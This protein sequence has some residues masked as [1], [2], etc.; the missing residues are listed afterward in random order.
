MGWQDR[1]YNQESNGGIPPVV[2]KFPKLSRLTLTLL[3]LNLALFLLKAVWEHGYLATLHW[4]ALELT[5]GHA[6]TQPWRWIT[7]QY[8]HGSGSHVFFNLIGLYFFLP[9]L[10]LTWGWRKALA[11]YTAG[12][13]VGGVVF[14]VY[15]AAI[16]RSEF[17]HIIGASGAVMSA[18]GAVA[19]LFPNRQ[20]ILLVFP[21][22]IRVAVALFAGL[23]ILTVLGDKSLSDACHLGGLAFGFFAPLLAGPTLHKY[24]Q[25]WRRRQ[26][27]RQANLEVDEQET[28]DR[29]LAKVSH[30]GMQSLTNAEKKA[31]KRATERQQRAEVSKGRKVF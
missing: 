30:E 4:G 1:A 27:N 9:T 15:A 3:V 6:F 10:E 20:L 28:I 26:V 23:Y 17:A 29:I 24:R 14:C 25:K 22:P 12:G 21:V 31:L 8:L 2:F 5:H 16:G 18:M 13:F 19:L 7:Y 11:F